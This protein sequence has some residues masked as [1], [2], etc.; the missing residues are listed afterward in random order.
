MNCLRFSGVRSDGD[1]LGRDRGP[2]DD[3]EVDPGVD[4][5][6]GVRLGVLRRQRAGRRHPGLADLGDPL[7]DQLRLDRLGVDLLHRP[8]GLHRV[9]DRDDLLQQRLRVVVP[10]PQALE[11]EHAETAEL[12]EQDRGGRR[13]HR[14]HRRGDQRE[15]EGVRVDPPGQRDLL[16]AAGA[17][18]RDDRDV[19]ERE[20][21]LGPLAAADLEHV[22]TLRRTRYA[23]PVV[24]RSCAS[25]RRRQ[26]GVVR[27]P[28]R[29]SGCRA[30]A[31]RAA[32]PR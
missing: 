22:V 7:A 17:A 4:H 9:L 1:V 15:L 26:P 19:V 30:G 32:R 6:L 23:G 31:T 13:H 25:R 14:V 27:A 3:E 10:G 24:A 20:C 18:G 29:S 12:A 8:G 16:L 11:V 2:P 28:R 5:R 21:L